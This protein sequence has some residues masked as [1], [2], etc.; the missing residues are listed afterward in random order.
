MALWDEKCPDM[1]RLFYEYEFRLRN[2]M[3]C[4]SFHI[5]VYTYYSE[6]KGL[7]QSLFDV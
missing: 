4:Y 1:F 6:G 5:L 3:K 2:A 7:S